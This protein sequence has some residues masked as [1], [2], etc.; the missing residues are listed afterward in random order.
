ML[1]NRCTAKMQIRKV[2]RILSSLQKTL[3]SDGKGDS[4]EAQR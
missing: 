4:N 1:M 2:D 3:P